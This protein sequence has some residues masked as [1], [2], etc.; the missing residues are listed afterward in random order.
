MNPVVH[1]EMPYKV[2]ARAIDF[3]QKTFGWK[4]NKLGSEMGD[5]ILVTT[6]ESDANPGLPAGAID[7]RLYPLKPDWPAQYPSIVIAV[8]DI[9]ESMNKIIE[10]GGEVLGEPHEI[11]GTGLYV[12]FFDT[13]GNRVSILEPKMQS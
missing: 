3:Y 2:G 1:F 13:E 5:Y 6:A 8:K 12:S 11:P 4:T 10:N 9:H 7:G